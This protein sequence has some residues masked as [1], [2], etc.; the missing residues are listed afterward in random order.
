MTRSRS[1]ITSTRTVESR[2]RFRRLYVMVADAQKLSP[3]IAA[4]FEVNFVKNS[5]AWSIHSR[6]ARKRSDRAP[7]WACS[8]SALFIAP[9]ITRTIATIRPARQAVPNEGPNAL[10][11]KKIPPVRNHRTRRMFDQKRTNSAIFPP[12]SVTA[13]L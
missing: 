6:H 8:L 13:T 2:F 9:R 10:L 3:V 1:E 7:C 4:K 11:H 5:T 12:D